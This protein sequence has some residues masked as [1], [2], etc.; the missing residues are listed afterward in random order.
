MK[1][2]ELIGAA[3]DWA[4]AQCEGF[5]WY[6]AEGVVYEERGEVSAT[7]E[8]SVRWAHAGPI[9]EREMISLNAH[10]PDDVEWVAREYWGDDGMTGP[11]PLIAAMRCYVM[12]NM[13][14]VVDVPEEL[15]EAV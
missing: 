7:F 15:L 14:T 12:N 10:E 13:G 8:P 9:I 11:T 6:I 5:D 4:V 3:L 2:N 1:T